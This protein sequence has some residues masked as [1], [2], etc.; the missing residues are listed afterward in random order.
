M[1]RILVAIIALGLGI[2][3]AQAQG[4]TGPVTAAQITGALGGT[5]QKVINVIDYGALC[6]WNGSTGTDDS[7]AINNAIAAIRTYFSSIP[8]G[9]FPSS[10]LVF[11]AQQNCLVKSPLNFT[12]FAH[13]GFT[14]DGNGAV[15]VGQTNG[16][17]VID[18]MGSRWIHFENLKIGGSTTLEPSIGLQVG[19][20]TNAINADIFNFDNLTVTGSFTFAAVYNLASETDV[21]NSPYI[22][23]N[24][25][26]AFYTGAISGTTLTTSAVT[27]AIAIGQRVIGAGVSMGTFI[28]A[29]SGSSWT[30]NISQTVSNEAMT[31]P[32]MALV[33][34]GY[35]YWGAYSPNASETIAPGTAQSFIGDVFTGGSYISSSGYPPVWLARTSGHSFTGSYFDNNGGSGQAIELWSL[36]GD[37]GTIDLRIQNGTHSE[38]SGITDIFLVSGTGTTTTITGLTYT[39]PDPYGSNSVFKIDPNS[40]LTSVGLNDARI[41]IELF[42]SGGT[43]KLFDNAS[44]WA[45]NAADIYLPASSNFTAPAAFNGR[46]CSASGCS[47]MGAGT[48][49]SAVPASFVNGTTLFQNSGSLGLLFKSKGSGNDYTWEDSAG[50]QFM[51][52]G[53]GSDILSVDALSAFGTQ[54]P[55]TGINRPAAGTLGLVAGSTVEAKLTTTSFALQSGVAL[56]ALSS[57]TFS[58]LSTSGTIAGAV[59]ATSAGLILYETGGCLLG[60]VSSVSGTAGQ[61]TVSPTTGAAVVSL[62]ATIT[63]AETFSS[64]L[65]ASAGLTLSGGALNV[66]SLT[67]SLPVYTDASKNLTSAAPS[68]VPTSAGAGLS[69]TGNVIS[70]NAAEHIS[71]QPGL[72]TSVTGTIAVFATYS[73]AAT[74]DNLIGSA[75][76][77]SCVSNPT[78]TLYECGTSATCAAPTTIGTVTVTAAGTR[79]TGTVSSPAIAAGDSIGWA[80]T[81]GTCTSLDISAVAQ[82]HS[83]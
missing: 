35:N 57:V 81:A 70:S 15:I 55:T 10:L 16:L 45:V 59:C 69:V 68:G 25:V 26:G 47:Y 4:L 83:N 13:S 78:V 6:N 48:G 75:Y 64:V 30:V 18:A 28:T 21:F 60:G 23:N 43:V 1:R 2:A 54:L 14:V 66:A 65:T 24:D 67:A 22:T 8:A 19:R 37:E 3:T 58:G 74:V 44:A 49:I 40:T 46:F 73:K 27:G 33:Q 63:Q 39:D 72:L 12:G 20:I 51:V 17:P 71:F 53:A 77:F 36:S 56:S 7:V 80:I 11:P 5:P 29:G 31:A 38:A 62:P 42:I 82:V 32:T 79:T 61:V 34:D 76:L 41:N 52:V 9:A 50:N